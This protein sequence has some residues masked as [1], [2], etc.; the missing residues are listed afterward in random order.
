MAIA[1]CEN[2]DGDEDHNPIVTLAEYNQILVGMTYDQVL[3]IIGDTPSNV[4]DNSAHSLIG[5]YWS[6]YDKS[7]CGVYFRR[8]SMTVWSKSNHGILR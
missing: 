6:N 8:T 5:Y 4:I 2:S 7:W 1:G 3:Q